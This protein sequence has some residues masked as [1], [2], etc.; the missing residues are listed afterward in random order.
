M[1]S[2][3]VQKAEIVNVAN[4]SKKV[5]CHFNPNELEITKLVEWVEKSDIGGDASQLVFGGGKAQDLS[6]PFLFDTTGTGRDVRNEYK[7]LVEM[8][9]IDASKKNPKTDQ[10]EPPQCMFQWGKFLSFT[11]VIK[12]I[13]QKFTMFKADGTPLR[14]QVTVTF[15]QVNLGTQPQNPTT[16]SEARRIWVVEEG[17]RLDWIANQEYGDPAHWRHIAET[18]NLDNPTDLHSGQVLKLVP[19]P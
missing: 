7:A 12:E 18:N 9:M 13:R 16:R 6:I 19:L 3:N 4:R 10:G 11:A 2:P 15:K 8:A 1:P 17:Q 5:T 14:A